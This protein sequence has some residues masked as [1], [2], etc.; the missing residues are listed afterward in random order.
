MCTIIV[1]VGR[2]VLRCKKKLTTCCIISYAGVL[3]ED[4]RLF[5]ETN[6]PKSTKKQKSQLGVG[7]T[8]I[9]ASISEELGMACPSTG[10]V[11]EIIRGGWRMTLRGC[12]RLLT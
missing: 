4:L 11:A 12:I 7:D 3:H 2:P 8:K 5:I 6:V 1:K 10:V 9:A